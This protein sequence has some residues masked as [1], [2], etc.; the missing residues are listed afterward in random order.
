MILDNAGVPIKSSYEVSLMPADWQRAMDCLA[1]LQ[2][3][4]QGSPPVPCVYL[5]ITLQA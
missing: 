4:A 2:Y 1:S 3:C 5:G